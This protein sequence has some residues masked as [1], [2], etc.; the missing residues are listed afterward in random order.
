MDQGP[1]Q[2]RETLCSPR[3]PRLPKESAAKGAKVRCP[4]LLPALVGTCGDRSLPARA[5]D[6][7]PEADYERLL[8]VRQR[9]ETVATSPFH[10]VQGMDPTDQGSVEESGKGLWAGA[11]EGTSAEM[12]RKDDA[13]GAVVEFLE[14]TR[15]GSRASTEAARARADE[16]RDGDEVPGQE[17]EDGP[18]RPRLYFPFVSFLGPFDI[19]SLC[20]A[21]LGRRRKGCPSITH[22]GWRQDLVM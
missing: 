12:A 15:V 9:Q 22:S 18:G 8:V 2:T 6:R 5:H 14:S 21:A 7:P 3:G 10:G 16:D 17:S 1:C 13:V 11:P 20:R 19:F 4:A